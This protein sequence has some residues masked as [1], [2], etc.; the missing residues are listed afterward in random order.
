MSTEWAMSAVATWGFGLASVAMLIVAS[1][2]PSI[3]V[4]GG[5]RFAARLVAP[6]RLLLGLSFGLALALLVGE[7]ARLD[8]ALGRL[9]APAGLAAAAFFAGVSVGRSWRGAAFLQA[10]LV[11]GFTLSAAFVTVLSPVGAPAGWRS[12]LAAVVGAAL[13]VLVM[14]LGAGAARRIW[15]AAEPPVSDAG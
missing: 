2:L 13:A 3:A 7:A 10:S 4:A 9:L 6:E 5:P 8:P 15:R 11:V 14:Q 12:E 1:V